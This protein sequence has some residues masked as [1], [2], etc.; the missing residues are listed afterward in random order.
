MFAAS[1]TFI[2]VLLI[3]AVSI[4]LIP[5][6]PDRS[7]GVEQST[8]I[9]NQPTS[10]YGPVTTAAPTS[11]T[12]PPAGIDDLVGEY[13]GRLI[14]EDEPG[15]P[16][17][18]HMVSVSIR[19]EGDHLAGSITH[20]PVGAG[21]LDKFGNVVMPLDVTLEENRLTMRWDE[22]I[23]SIVD[24]TFTM[25]TWE[26]WMMNL[27]VEEGGNLLVLV[28]GFVDGRL[29]ESTDVSEWYIG[30]PAGERPMVRLTLVRQ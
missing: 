12:P 3:S 11:T 5:D 30:C 8:T 25:C 13:R 23:G 14:R 19:E 16:D 2:A 4:W 29:P 24:T 20:G 26:A 17:T 6:R 27:T 21:S 7:T 9:A 15:T 1:I 28:D 22:S 18:F 10:I